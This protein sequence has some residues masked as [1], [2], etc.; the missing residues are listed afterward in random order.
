MFQKRPAQSRI[1]VLMIRSLNRRTVEKDPLTPDEIRD[2][3]IARLMTHNQ[4][5]TL[6]WL[7]REWQSG[8]I[9]FDEFKIAV[10]AVRNEE[11]R[12]YEGPKGAA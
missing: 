6:L 2:H 11:A 1:E 5:T 3:E 7:I 9:A 8:R 4:P 10:D 12:Y